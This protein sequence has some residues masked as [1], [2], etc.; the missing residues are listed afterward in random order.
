MRRSVRL[1]MAALLVTVLLV[2]GSL[3]LSFAGPAERMLILYGA[4]QKEMARSAILDT[5]GVI[6]YEFDNINALAV[7]V[8]TATKTQLG[9]RQ[10]ILSMEREESDTKLVCERWKPYLVRERTGGAARPWEE[11]RNWRWAIKMSRRNAKAVLA[12][13]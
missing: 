9:R 1:S 12:G 8:D 5:G 10:G 11:G 3:S 4:G 13:P 2:V 7:T 6:H